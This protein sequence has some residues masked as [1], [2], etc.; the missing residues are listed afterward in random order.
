MKVAKKKIE[1]LETRSLPG[2]RFAAE[3]GSLLLATLPP[4]AYWRFRPRGIGQSH[5]VR[6]GLARAGSAVTGRSALRIFLF[7]VRLG[8]LCELDLRDGRAEARAEEVKHVQIRPR[9]TP[10]F[11]RMMAFRGQRLLS[12]YHQARGA[13]DKKQQALVQHH[14][15]NVWQLIAQQV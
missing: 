6:G 5:K 7:T 1:R 14:Q 13:R 9:L 4:A 8:N 11:P 3:L 12:R 2:S 10:V 15:W